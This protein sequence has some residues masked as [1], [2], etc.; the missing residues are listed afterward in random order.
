MIEKQKVEVE[1]EALI[2]AVRFARHEVGCP[3]GHFEKRHGRF[4]ANH[5]VWQN[6]PAC[7]CY[8]GKIKAALEG[9]R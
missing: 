9:A 2:L 1:R 5:P 7:D 4:P 6:L 8:V 3:L